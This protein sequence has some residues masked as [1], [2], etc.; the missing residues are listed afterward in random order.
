MSDL[1]DYEDWHRA[2]DDPNSDLSWRLLRV[3]EYI[4]QA[5]D[6]H[7]GSVQALSAC[8][9]DGRDIL[10]VLSERDDADRV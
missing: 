8:S 1:R 2:Y 10:G 9:G 4:R 3:Q 6:D 5:L 7:R